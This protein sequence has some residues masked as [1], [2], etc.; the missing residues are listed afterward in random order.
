MAEVAAIDPA[1]IDIRVQ[2]GT[3]NDFEFILTDGEGDAV[4]IAADDVTLTIKDDFDG[5][6]QH[7]QTSSAGSHLD[8]DG[9]KVE[10]SIPR[11]DI[12]DEANPG[13]QTS[14]V[15]EV[16]RIIGGGAGDQIVHIKGEFTIE[17]S[18]GL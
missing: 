12:D 16:R 13:S 14:W 4:G 11:T 1:C 18:V 15:Y 6:V 8:A 3:D 7:Q 10:F 5:A 2:R 9:G 17:P